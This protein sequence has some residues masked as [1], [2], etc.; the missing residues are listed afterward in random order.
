MSVDIMTLCAILVVG[1]SVVSIP[2]QM[3]RHLREDFES[4][5]ESGEKK[6]DR[7][8]LQLEKCSDRLSETHTDYAIV[9]TRLDL[10]IAQR[11]K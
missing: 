11:G 7:I 10:L 5:L 9:K 3:I 8:L 1:V 6:F 2:I 4:K